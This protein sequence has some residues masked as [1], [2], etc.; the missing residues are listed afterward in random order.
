MNSGRR[1]LGTFNFEF[2]GC[3]AK[4]KTNAVNIAICF[5]LPAIIIHQRGY[6]MGVRNRTINSYM[7]DFCQSVTQW[8]I[9]RIHINP[10]YLLPVFI[11]TLTFAQIQHVLSAVCLINIS[12]TVVTLLLSLRSSY[13]ITN[14]TAPYPVATARFDYCVAPKILCLRPVSRFTGHCCIFSPQCLKQLSTV[15]CK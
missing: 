9:Y 1:T 11:W 2:W 3:T 4:M 14:I 12:L 5:Q 7:H 6:E 10:G 8:T 13:V 15:N